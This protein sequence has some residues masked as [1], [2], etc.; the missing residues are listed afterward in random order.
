MVILHSDFNQLT[1]KLNTSS[2]RYAA[3]LECL[4]LD[5]RYTRL[6]F[7]LFQCCGLSIWAATCD[8]V[9]MFA[10]ASFIAILQYFILILVLLFIADTY[11]VLS[12]FI[13]F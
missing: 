7:L 2:V 5:V 11:S 12:L 3:M 6:H 13:L 8:L 9:I 1:W 10:A 4:Q